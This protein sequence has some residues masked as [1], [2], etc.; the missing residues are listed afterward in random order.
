MRLT[1]LAVFAPLALLAACGGNP[2]DL[3]I[4]N[5]A[6]GMSSVAAEK[7]RL[8]ALRQGGTLE[9]ARLKGMNTLEIRSIL[10]KPGFT[11]RDAPAEIWQYRG[12]ICTLDLF[13]YDDASGQTVAHYA[14]RGA[15]PVSEGECVNE[16]VGRNAGTPTS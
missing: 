10:G 3:T 12:R 14:V 8:A 16:L 2:Q 1:H 11:R 15:M 4:S 5:G 6:S 7:A 13:L 9:P